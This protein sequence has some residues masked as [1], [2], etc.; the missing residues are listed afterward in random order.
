MRTPDKF[1]ERN[2]LPCGKIIAHDKRYG[3]EIILK[4]LAI[5]FIA[6]T[7]TSSYAEEQMSLNEFC[8]S[9]PC[10]KDLTIILKQRDGTEFKNTFDLL[11]PVIQPSFI[12]IYAGETIYIEALEG[13]EA[14]T[15]FVQVKKVM[16]PEK[17]ITM[18]FQQQ[19]DIGN[20][21]SM[22]LTVENPFS[23]AIRY[24]MGIMPLDQER[25]LKTS[26]CPVI[27]KGSVFEIWPFPIFQIVVANIH[28]QK[29]SDDGA[30]K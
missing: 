15:D 29:E 23:K 18:K 10:R 24:S 7:A 5:I 30:C 14:P 8:K 11:P 1:E 16:K 6:I 21:K 4:Y 12:S 26:S 27:A 20:G 17:T 25:L 28:F 2:N 9:N 22:L 19:K 3:K 13:N